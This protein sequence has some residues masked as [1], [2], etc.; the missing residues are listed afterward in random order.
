[1]L[2]SFGCH[3]HHVTL[4]CNRAS[5]WIL[6]TTSKCHSFFHTPFTFS[7]SATSARWLWGETDL[8]LFN[9][10]P[11][12]M[13]IMFHMLTFVRSDI[14][15]HLCWRHLAPQGSLDNISIILLCFPGAPQLSA[16]ALHQE[17]ELEDLL[18]SK[19]AGVWVIMIHRGRCRK[20]M[21]Y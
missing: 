3:V 10:S 11:R 6:T 20:V 12:I 9:C 13:V 18:E 21:S 8:Y 1:M 15:T 14:I 5:A 19:V 7:C 17:A 16:E 2:H 4:L